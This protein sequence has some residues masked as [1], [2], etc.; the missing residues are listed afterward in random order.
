MLSF[1]DPSSSSPALSN[2]WDHQSPIF[3]QHWWWTRKQQQQP[4]NPCWVNAEG[5]SAQP[6][7][8]NFG[9]TPFPQCP[10]KGHFLLE[11]LLLS[12]KL[13]MIN[14][15]ES[16][17]LILHA[18]DLQL[19]RNLTMVNFRSIAFVNPRQAS[20]KANRRFYCKN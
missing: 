12:E 5:W 6:F 16:Q 19:S 15:N 9:L 14:F 1:P 3:A 4:G 13:K 8:I 11:S 10:N 17:E 2:Q 20:Q 7:S 18:T